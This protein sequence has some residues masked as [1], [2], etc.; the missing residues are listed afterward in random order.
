MARHLSFWIGFFAAALVIVPV[1]VGAWGVTQG[2]ARDWAATFFI[3]ICTMVGLLVMGLL[4]RGAILR[5]LTGRAEATVEDISSTLIS[6]VS[7][8]VAQDRATAEREA[9]K[10]ARVVLGWYAWSNFYRWVIGTALALLLAFASFT[11]TV[12]LFEQIAKLEDQTRVMQA[13]QELM[14]AQTR[15]MENQT[16]RLEEQSRAAAMQNEIEMLNLV[17]Q[18]RDQMLATIETKPLRDWLRRDGRSGFEDPLVSLSTDQQACALGFNLDHVMSGPPSPAIRGAIVNLTLSPML[19]PQV[20]TALE[21][22]VQDG[23]GGVA[24]GAL[25]I[26]ER[27][28]HSVAV[29]RI[30]VQD[31]MMQREVVLKRFNGEIVFENAFLWGFECPDCDFHIRGSYLNP[32]DVQ[33]KTALRSVITQVDVNDPPV[34][35]IGTVN[36]GIPLP[37]EWPGVE[38][39]L[40]PFFFAFEQGWLF[41]TRKG[42]V[43]AN[44]LDLAKLTPM[45]EDVTVASQ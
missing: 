30:F 6:G 19:G 35:A 13:Q 38:V 45:Y 37:I 16:Q 42:P 29:D 5:R 39:A 7:A 9:D 21:L 32:T 31:V 1:A 25:Q 2:F 27:A 20:L 34:V 26:L 24:L 36:Q 40:G 17:N 44:L 41:H 8:A 11:G 10:L 3:V 22:L 18:L 4:F 23:H 28:G 15:F 43:C 12:L 14:D 33:P